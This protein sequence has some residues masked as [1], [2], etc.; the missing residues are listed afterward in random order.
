V[1]V[2]F[3]NNLSPRLARA[4]KAFFD[5]QHEI[6]HLREKFDPRIGDKEMIERLS[7][8]GAWVFVSGDRRITKNAAERE[9]FRGSKLI[10]IFLS[11]GLNKAPEIKK[12]ER[13][14]AIWHAIERLVPLVEPGAMF[15]IPMKSLK[16][17]QIK[18]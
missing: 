10:G 16:L 2:F 18:T 8:E 3:D 11:S 12:L 15:E 4:L 7:D 9:A 17:R 13:I 5:Q 1:K 6:T 14:L